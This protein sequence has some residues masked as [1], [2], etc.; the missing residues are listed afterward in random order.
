MRKFRALMGPF[1]DL[2]IGK[3]VDYLTHV[4]SEYLIS[5]MLLY[6]TSTCMAGQISCLT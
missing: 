3:Y 2:K 1:W 5:C 4:S 6:L